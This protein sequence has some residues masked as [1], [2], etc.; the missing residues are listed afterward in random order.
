[1]TNPTVRPD[2]ISVTHF[3]DNPLHVDVHSNHTGFVV[4]CLNRVDFHIHDADIKATA[5]ALEVAVKTLRH[6]LKGDK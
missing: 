1:M 2:R 3:S 6:V 5:D 4:L